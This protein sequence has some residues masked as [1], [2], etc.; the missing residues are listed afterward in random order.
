MLF[1][2][3]FKKAFIPA[4]R[5]YERLKEMSSDPKPMK[6]QKCGDVTKPSQVCYRLPLET[7]QN[8]PDWSTGEEEISVDDL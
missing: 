5:D 6:G 4:R 1:K 8:P 2:T 7:S 3:D